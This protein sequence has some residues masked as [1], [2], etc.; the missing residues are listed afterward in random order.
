VPARNE[1]RVI[2]DCV[3]ALALQPEVQ[4]IIVVNDGSVDR[5]AEI[6]RGLMRAWPRLRLLNVEEPP[7]RWL[8]KNNAAWHGAKATK[9][10]W[11]LFTDADAELQPGAAKRALEIAQEYDSALISFSPEQLMGSWYEKALIPF[12]YCRLAKYFSFEAVNDPASSAAAANGQFLMI[13]RHAYDAI[14]GH[15]RI[16]GEV[17]EDVALAK[18]AKA[19]G[20]RLWFGTG[21]GLVRTRM[22]RSFEA[23]W[24]GW[25]KNLYLLVGGTPKSVYRELLAV[26]PWIPLLLLL[27]GMKLPFALLLGIALL[28]P[29]HVGYGLDLARNQYKASHII[30]YLPALALYAGVLWVSYRAHSKGLVQWKG[31][32][33]SVGLPAVLKRNSG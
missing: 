19:A 31:R 1:E 10:R 3:A 15:A 17:L 7:P 9:S 16:A 18:R 2:A 11:L 29:R 32:Q 22:Y 12:V 4:E 20:F 6:V 8:G 33:V 5:T 23:M 21:N 24:E 30:Y 14:G 28:V 27:A 25:K 13:R 26:F